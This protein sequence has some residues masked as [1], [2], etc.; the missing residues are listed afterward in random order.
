M[1]SKKDLNDYITTVKSLKPSA[2]VKLRTT[3]EKGEVTETVAS[4]EY[5]NKHANKE[6]DA[7]SQIRGLTERLNKV[8][9]K[10]TAQQAV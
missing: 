6:V 3:N 7:V 4:C 5:I 1:A 10:A 9:E 2:E 8:T